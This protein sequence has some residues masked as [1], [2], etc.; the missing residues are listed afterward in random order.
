MGPR[1]HIRIDGAK[2]DEYIGPVAAV[3][4]ARIKEL[5]AEIDLAQSLASASGRPD[6]RGLTCL[7]V[8]PE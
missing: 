2:V 3:D 5:R 4:K 8:A 1:E 6:A 7:R